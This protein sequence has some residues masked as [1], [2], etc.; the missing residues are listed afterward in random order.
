[1]KWQ[2]YA[3]DVGTP[4]SRQ[5]TNNQY[6]QKTALSYP[7]GIILR[8]YSFSFLNRKDTCICYTMPRRK[9]ETY[10][11]LF[12]KQKLKIS[13]EIVLIFLTF[14]LKTYIVGYTLEPPSRHNVCFKS[15]I[16]KLGIAMQT[17][18]FPYKGGV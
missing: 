3:E 13:S 1:M 5:I 17:P 14:S 15:K 11:E 8:N 6:T 2:S 4:A 12:R 10:R 18:V 7:T 9:Y 16:R